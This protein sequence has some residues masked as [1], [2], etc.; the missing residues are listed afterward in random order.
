[1]YVGFQ[2]ADIRRLRLKVHADELAPGILYP[3]VYRFVN[4]HAMASHFVIVGE[5]FRQ[6]ER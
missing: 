3:R 4:H 2:G 5:I 1:M 6:A